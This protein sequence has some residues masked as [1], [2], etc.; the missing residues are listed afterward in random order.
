[1]KDG[2]SLE[3][4]ENMDGIEQAVLDKVIFLL[5]LLSSS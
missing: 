5:S 3:S 4:K 1:M 2:E